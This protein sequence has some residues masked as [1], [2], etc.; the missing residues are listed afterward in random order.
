MK[1]KL[2]AF[3]L[4]ICAAC[5]FVSIPV[6]V[7]KDT[8]IEIYVPVRTE[9]Q[10]AEHEEAQQKAAQAA[11]QKAKAR[12]IYRC[13]TND[14][15]VI[16]DKDPCGCAVGP[17]GVTAINVDFIL[18]FS[19]TKSGVLAKACPDRAPSQERECSPNAQAVCRENMCHITY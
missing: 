3:L 10:A 7:A 2:R 13:Q 8:P 18:E 9:K 19:K 17:S 11:A 5:V 4:L 14:D 16:V 1:S 15:C 6:F 12:R